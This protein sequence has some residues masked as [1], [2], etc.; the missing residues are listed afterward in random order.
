VYEETAL[1]HYGQ[2]SGEGNVVLADIDMTDGDTYALERWSG[3]ATART[4]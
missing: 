1:G 4:N 3:V 2:D